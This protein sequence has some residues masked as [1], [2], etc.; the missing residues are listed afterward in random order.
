MRAFLALDTA[1]DHVALALG[2]LDRPGVV[3]AQSALRAP[4]SANTMMLAEAERLLHGARLT[5]GDLTAVACGRGPGS[6]TGVRIAVATAKGLAHG[7]GIP[8]VGFSTLDAVASRWQGHGLLAVV[9]DAMRGE[10]YP[11][12]FRVNGGAPRRLTEDTVV[13]PDAIASEW[14]ALGEAL[15]LTG[16]GLVKHREV[17]A[18]ALGDAAGFAEER[19]WAPDGASL[20]AATWAAE[21]EPS[22]RTIADLEPAD[23]FV[24]AHPALLLPTYTRLSD[25]EE[26]ERRAVP[27]A[28]RAVPGSGVAGPEARA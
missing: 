26:A 11:A 1:T 16:S 5:V 27:P 10:V 22:L 4:R 3:L 24:A 7:S 8:L 13:R 17:F 23:A 14:A 19:L 25:A 9:G 12:L 18:Q 28:S 6:F 20:I 2:D 15:T 21:E